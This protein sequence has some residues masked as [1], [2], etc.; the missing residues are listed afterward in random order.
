MTS[1]VFMYS[2]SLQI[3]ETVDNLCETGEHKCD[4][5]A[6]CSFDGREAKCL[7]SDPSRL[8]GHGNLCTSYRPLRGLD[9]LDIAITNAQIIKGEL[10]YLVDLNEH[11]SDYAFDVKHCLELGPEILGNAWKFQLNLGERHYIKAVGFYNR[12]DQLTGN[13]ISST[14]PVHVCDDSNGCFPCEGGDEKLKLTGVPGWNYVMCE[15][16]GDSLK[17]MTAADDLSSDEA[18]L[19]VCEVEI[20]SQP[21]APVGSRV[22]PIR[23]AFYSGEQSQLLD[24]Q[25]TSVMD[26]IDNVQ[27]SS[28]MQLVETDH[29]TK[30]QIYRNLTVEVDLNF[31]GYIQVLAPNHDSVTSMGAL[32]TSQCFLDSTCSVCG[33][34]DGAFKGAW[35]STMCVG[36]SNDDLKAATSV[37]ISPN[38]GHRRITEDL[39]IC[40]IDVFERKIAVQVSAN[41]RALSPTSVWVSWFVNVLGASTTV[42]LSPYDPAVPTTTVQHNSDVTGSREFSGLKPGKTIV[43]KCA[44]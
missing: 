28:C 27:I 14:V 3:Q 10:D 42:T 16:I 7:C 4:E 9:S 24:N 37:K 20:L 34:L 40:G 43:F 17:I 11:N 8:F 30:E 33:T 12:R 2:H 13:L 44:F 15:Q 25:L 38:T 5:L 32:Q 29:F 21:V 22:L 31:V 36:G 35:I 26:N 39:Y 41:A 1:E 23:G 18:K 6:V 19:G